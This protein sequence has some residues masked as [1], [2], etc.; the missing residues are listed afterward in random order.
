MEDR[1]F[2]PALGHAALTPLYDVAISLLTRERTWRSALAS[3][4]NL[5]PE[6]RVLD[7]GCGT[8][9]F[10]I[11][12]KCAV[13]NAWVIGL[14]P[15][16]R[17]LEQAQR[18]ANEQNA[19]VEWRQ[20]FLS[21]ELVTELRPLTSVVSS[22]VFHQTPI[23]EKQRILGAMWE[24]LEPGGRLVIADYGEQRTRTMRFLFRRTVQ[25]L[26]GVEDTTPNAEGCLPIYMREA[27]FVDVEE[28]AVINTLTGSISIYQA[29]KPND[30]GV[31]ARR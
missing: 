9:T 25:T 15:D 2:T 1:S 18:K 20:G 26:D 31:Y 23:P 28:Q 10:A 30:G 7:V 11:Q 3:A 29:R 8:G 17:V 4:L 24:A 22:L 5:L 16:P 21:D 14:D 27:G 6:E 13:P 12:L 19:D